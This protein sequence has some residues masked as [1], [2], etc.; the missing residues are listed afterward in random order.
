MTTTMNVETL[1]ARHENVQNGVEVKGKAEAG[2]SFEPYLKSLS[3]FTKV[4]ETPA[5]VSDLRRSSLHVDGVYPKEYIKQNEK[6][7]ETYPLHM[8]VGKAFAEIRKIFADSG[9]PISDTA[10]ITR[11]PTGKFTVGGWGKGVSVTHPQKEAIEA[12][13][14]GEIP[15]LSSETKKIHELIDQAEGWFAQIQN[16]EE[17]YEP[18]LQSG[19]VRKNSLFDGGHMVASEYKPQVQNEAR[20]YSMNNRESFQDFN[21]SLGSER[22]DLSY[23]QLLSRFYFENVTKPNFSN[24]F[25]EYF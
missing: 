12:I 5:L 8:K 6:M 23:D 16:I 20:L 19:F 21:T 17:R 3:Q 22:L 24:L 4:S 1:F 25:A 14:N 9:M 7:N 15:S 11:S 10:V 2:T 13:L 18:E